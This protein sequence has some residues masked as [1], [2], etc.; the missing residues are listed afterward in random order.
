MPYYTIINNISKK[1]SMMRRVSI[2]ISN[3]EQKVGESSARKRIGK[4]ASEKLPE[5]LQGC[6]VNCV[7]VLSGLF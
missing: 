4:R 5:H 3:S 1:N 2:Y 7:K 6:V